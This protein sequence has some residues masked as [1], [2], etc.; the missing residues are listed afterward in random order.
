MSEKS[1]LEL[2]YDYDRNME[3]LGCKILRKSRK[4]A[5]IL[6]FV[7]LALG[8]FTAVT[9]QFV[10]A[11]IGF[12]FAIV[13]FVRFYKRGS[14]LKDIIYVRKVGLANSKKWVKGS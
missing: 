5:L 13:A 3:E 6:T 12:V 14:Q 1:N 9:D 4:R 7:F 2:A 8:I 10:I 11:A